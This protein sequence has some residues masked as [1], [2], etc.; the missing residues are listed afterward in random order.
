V[1]APNEMAQRNG[2]HSP[3][4]AGR[5]SALSGFALADASAAVEVSALGWLDVL[6]DL[7]P[8]RAEDRRGAGSFGASAR[9]L[10][11]DRTRHQHVGKKALQNL[12]ATDNGE[13]DERSCVADDQGADR[14]G[15]RARGR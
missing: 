9:H 7:E 15:R 8:A 6:D 12:E 1:Y 5:P 4:G 11:D 2:C 13:G 10:L 3:A 14:A